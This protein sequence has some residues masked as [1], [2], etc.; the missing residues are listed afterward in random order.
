M[1]QLKPQDL[2][3]ENYVNYNQMNLPI[4][5]IRSPKPLKDKRFADKW[6]IELFDGASTIDCTIDDIHPIPITEEILL[7]AGF[8]HTG[9]GFYTHLPSLIQACNIGDQFYNMGFKDANIGRFYHLNQLQNIFH[10]L[11]GE[12]L[13]INLK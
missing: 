3:I 2:R 12:E 11:T 8:K 7:M 9:G 5:G 4:Y 13:E 10:S 6:L 1:S